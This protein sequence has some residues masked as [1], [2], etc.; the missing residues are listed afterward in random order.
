MA[1]AVAKICGLWLEQSQHDPEWLVWVSHQW[2]QVFVVLT[3]CRM[4]YSIATGDV[5]SKPVAAQWARNNL[6]QRWQ[7]LIA[8][9]LAKK[10]DQ[11]EIDLGELAE[12]IAF[13]QYAFDQSQVENKLA[14][15]ADQF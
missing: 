11:N 9:S 14:Q 12:T 6:N 5:A 1:P 15:E 13:I 4:L 8:S 7:S 10:E 2:C 3:L